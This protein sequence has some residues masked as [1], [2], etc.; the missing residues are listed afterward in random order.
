LPTRGPLR[1]VNRRPCRPA[2]LTTAGDVETYA[3]P[4]PTGKVNVQAGQQSHS[5]PR[6]AQ[7]RRCHPNDEE[8]APGGSRVWSGR[9]IRGTRKCVKSTSPSYSQVVNI[10]PTTTTI[11]SSVNPSQV[12]QLVTFTAT[13]KSNTITPQAIR[14]CDLHRRFDPL[15]HGNPQEWQSY[16]RHFGVECRLDH[17]HRNL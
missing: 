13:V 9:F 10:T 12:G 2:A 17:N 4:V 3:G 7:Q 16:C 6:H 1:G 5:W 15:G 11:M 8:D 14:N